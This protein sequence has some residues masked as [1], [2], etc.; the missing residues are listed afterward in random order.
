MQTKKHPVLFLDKTRYPL[1]NRWDLLALALLFG[2]LGW[3]A[4]GGADMTTPYELGQ[5]LPISLDP[6]CLPGY[7]GLTVLRMLVALILS[8]AFT[9]TVGSIAAKNHQAARFI[10]PCIDVLQSV[11]VL[12][13]LSLTVTGF[14]R[15][16][17]GSRLGPE[18]A[19][20]FAI[21]TAQV[22]NMTLSFYQSIRSVP[23]DLMEATTLFQLSAW[24]RF[25]RLEVPFALPG[26]LWNMMLSMS[27][28][29]VF[30]VASES[31]AVAKYTIH[32]PGVGS[33]LGL[34]INSGSLTGIAW[35][36][37]TML[38][39]IVIY[40]QLFFRPL[41]A[42][43]YKF[44]A[45]DSVIEAAPRAWLTTLLQRTHIL[46][47]LHYLM[48][49]GSEWF[50]R[51]PFYKFPRP[52]STKKTGFRKLMLL[53]GL[54]IKILGWGM[55]LYMLKQLGY[56]GIRHIHWQDSIHTLVLGGI[57]ALRVLTV[58]VLSSLIWVPIGVW[59]GLRPR[60]TAIIQPIVQF[61][62]AFPAN[63]LFPFVVIF[64]LKFKLSFEFGV[65]PLMLLGSQ[66]Y[67]LFNVI[68]GVS[69]IPKELYQI[70]QN[71]G[72]NR[73]LWW[74]RLLLPGIF[75]YLIIGIMTAV[76]AAWNISVV[77]EVIQWGPTTLKAVGLG[78][79]IDQASARGDLPQ[80]ATGMAAMSLWVL[81][82]NY[83]LWQPL[84]RLAQSKYRLN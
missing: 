9:L 1:P 44:N 77:A 7:A 28:S 65:L 68:A 38:V 35:A 59:I 76:G 14:I 80:V 56:Y 84:Y 6:R 2:L 26:L 8:L 67:I 83:L 33:Y 23:L 21:F 60:L 31:I 36:V 49:Y 32:L 37:G 24:Q 34:A 57:T 22:W 69:A 43:S 54:I 58:V 11:P 81:T 27:G 63:V 41:I 19:A 5:S 10:I 46:Q 51:G 30:L 42:W 17:P 16:F 45:Q 4:W 3:L 64:L 18:F 79:Y 52:P 48:R 40:D 50:L 25:W 72:V 55:G 78:A 29:W 47:Q 74:K 15:L 70:A 75:P 12:G 66:W 13:F 73:W 82:M 39:V 61:L 71:L 20:I 53:Q 62:A